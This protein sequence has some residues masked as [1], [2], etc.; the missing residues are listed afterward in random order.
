MYNRWVNKAPL[1]LSLTFAIWYYIYWTY[2]HW[3]L[4]N[5]QWNVQHTVLPWPKVTTTV[6]INHISID[7]H[8]L[9]LCSFLLT[10]TA[11]ICWSRKI[12]MVARRAGIKASRMRYHSGK[13]ARGLTSQPRPSSVVLNSVGTVSLGVSSFR[14]MSIPVHTRI[15]INTA[16]SAT[17]PLTYQEPTY[18]YYLVKLFSQLML[19]IFDVLQKSFR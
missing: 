2:I 13:R 7:A 3:P 15:E 12:R 4:W 10:M 9:S 8:T 17:V 18:T 14:A 1:L 5:M 16:K 11:V 19:Y 6:N